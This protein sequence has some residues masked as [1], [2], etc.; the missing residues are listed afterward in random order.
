MRLSRSA[1]AFTASTLAVPAILFAA[2]GQQPSAQT[3]E[4]T[5]DPA[6]VARHAKDEALA[7]LIPAGIRDL[8]RRDP[9]VAAILQDIRATEDE[10][11]HAAAESRRANDPAV[12]AAR[13][14]L[15]R[16]NAK[17]VALM[18]DGYADIRRQV[19]AGVNVGSQEQVEKRIRFLFKLDPAVASLIQD[20]VAR[21]MNWNA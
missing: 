3:P 19:M 5:A 10:L 20:I 12:V 6:A 8:L 1:F 7:A 4:P 21:R 18:S 15:D 2:Y 17:Y 11:D 14:R 13:R 9:A 16:L